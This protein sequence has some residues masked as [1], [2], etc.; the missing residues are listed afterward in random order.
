M[1]STPAPKSGPKTL[2]DSDLTT[3]RRR[4]GPGRNSAGTGSDADSHAPTDVDQHSDTDTDVQP[5]TDQDD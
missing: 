1:A 3:F 4:P 5:A 2:T